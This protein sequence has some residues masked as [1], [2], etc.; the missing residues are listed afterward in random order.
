M[1]YE[2]RPPE[3][4]RNHLPRLVISGQK[5]VAIR[6]ASSRGAAWQP[7]EDCRRRRTAARRCPSRRNT[8]RNGVENL[9]KPMRRRANDS[10]QAWPR[11]LYTTEKRLRAKIGLQCA[12]LP[13]GTARAFVRLFFLTGEV[14]GSQLEFFRS[15]ASARSQF[16]SASPPLAAQISY[17][18]SRIR[19]RIVSSI[20]APSSCFSLRD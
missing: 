15:S 19:T 3:I 5:I 7:I 2:K 16:S 4:A 18:R 14:I 8:F 20:T 13:F 1:R 6:C 9:E 12:T 17:A 10:D 11:T